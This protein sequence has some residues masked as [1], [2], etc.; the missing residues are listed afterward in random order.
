MVASRVFDLAQGECVW[1]YECEVSQLVQG[2]C[3]PP[4]GGGG[5][6]GGVYMIK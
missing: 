3:S 5:G 1:W 4:G 6:G 2:P